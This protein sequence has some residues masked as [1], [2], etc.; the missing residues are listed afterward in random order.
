[1]IQTYNVRYWGSRADGDFLFTW[2]YSV[3]LVEITLL[4]HGN[5]VAWV[6]LW[7]HLSESCYVSQN[8]RLYSNPQADRIPMVHDDVIKWK[9]FLR[10]WPFVRGIHRWPVNSPLKGQWREALMFSLICAWI[11]VWVNNREASDL[12]RHL[13][14]YDVTVMLYQHLYCTHDINAALNAF[15]SEVVWITFTM[16]LMPWPL[17]QL[18]HFP[19]KTSFGC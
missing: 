7:V 12:R 1:M 18:W 10:Y 15:M 17:Q 9:H 19:C 2:C 13:S 5:W 16:N 11:N 14:H 4:P 6:L 3:C 8:S